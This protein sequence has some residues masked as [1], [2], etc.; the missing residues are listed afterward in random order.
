[1]FAINLDI[2]NSTSKA[3][4]NGCCKHYHYHLLTNGEMSRT[5]S[6]VYFEI[7]GEG[8]CSCRVLKTRGGVQRKYK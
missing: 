4:I 1:M 3:S 8:C 2:S 6:V 5:N 7:L